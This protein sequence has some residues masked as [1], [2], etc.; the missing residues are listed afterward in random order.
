MRLMAIAACAVMIAACTEDTEPPSSDM[1]SNQA[2]AQNDVLPGPIGNDVLEESAPANAS[3]STA[4]P[5]LMQGNEKLDV[6][7]TKALG[8]EPFWGVKIEGRCLTYSTPEDQAG[9]RI[10]TKYQIVPDGQVWTGTFQNQPFKLIL[11][12]K[13]DCS[14]G[15]SDRTY[16]TEAL[17]TVAGEE[18]RGCAFPE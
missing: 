1:S 11:Q 8:T 5:C 15:M 13:P 7:P 18:R 3:T 17:L 16:S 2:Q 10:W 6:P 4:H 12:A 14:D 9:T